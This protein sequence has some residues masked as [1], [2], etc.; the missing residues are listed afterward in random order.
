MCLVEHAKNQALVVAFPVRTVRMQPHLLERMTPM[1]LTAYKIAPQK[2]PLAALIDVAAA[3]RG[4]GIDMS[5]PAAHFSK[6]AAT[7]AV[8]N[9]ENACVG[10]NDGE[11]AVAKDAVL[12]FV[13]AAQAEADKITG[14]RS[15]P[16]PA[17]WLVEWRAGLKELRTWAES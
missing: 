10:K 16:P 5:K 6:Q 14:G 13:N 3:C 7:S 8:N 17:K 15:A 9:L 4:A 11:V 12:K 2:L 1:R